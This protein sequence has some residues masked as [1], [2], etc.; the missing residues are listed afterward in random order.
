MP[1]SPALTES[2][3]TVCTSG[4]SLV[5]TV[6]NEHTGLAVMPFG[7]RK[8]QTEHSI[9]GR[10]RQCSPWYTSHRIGPTKHSHWRN[11]GC[12]NANRWC[13]RRVYVRRHRL[14]CTSTVF[15]PPLSIVK[16]LNYYQALVSLSISSY[17]VI[18]LYTVQL[19]T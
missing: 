2:R 13:R 12:R 5:K 3:Y 18:W 17:F 6:I 16:M 19:G 10:R 7:R 4:Y 11:V 14:R 15:S 8:H 9:I 1:I